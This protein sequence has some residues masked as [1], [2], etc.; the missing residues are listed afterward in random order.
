MDFGV[1][2]HILDKRKFVDELFRVAV[3]S[4]EII[5]VTLCHRDLEERGED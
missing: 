4:G 5:I 3:P 2:V 1:G